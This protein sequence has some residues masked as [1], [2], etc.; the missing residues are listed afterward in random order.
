MITMCVRANKCSV[1]Y[2][3]Y[4]N[5]LVTINFFLTLNFL[6]ASSEFTGHYHMDDQ[7]WQTSGVLQ[8]AISFTVVLWDWSSMWKILWKNN[9]DSHEGT[10]IEKLVFIISQDY[11]ESVYQWHIKRKEDQ[12]CRVALFSFFLAFC[13][14]S[15]LIMFS[16]RESPRARTNATEREGFFVSRCWVIHNN[17]C[18]WSFAIK[19]LNKTRVMDRLPFVTKCLADYFIFVFLL[20]PWLGMAK[21]PLFGCLTCIMLLQVVRKSWL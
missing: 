7:W 15:F 6:V 13:S 9:R 1:K 18:A 3:K 12:R 19:S 14:H 17:A 2:H 8:N 20:L 4:S 5:T 21:Q 10:F 16:F 11:L